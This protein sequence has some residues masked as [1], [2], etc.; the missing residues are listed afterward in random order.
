MIDSHCH[1]DFAAFDHDREQV[2]QRA[3]SLGVNQILVPGTQAKRWQ[4]QRAICQQF[5]NLKFA[6]GLHP[7]FLTEFNREDL[8]TLE[9]SLKHCREHVTAVGEIGLDFAIDIDRALQEDVFIQQLSIAKQA[10]LPVILHHRKSHNDLIRILKSTQFHFGGVIHAFSGSYQ[11]G[12]AYVD[13]G[14]KLGVGGTIT[15]PRAVK[16]IDAIKRLPLESLLLETDAPDMPMSGR[17]GERN[18][19]EYLPDVLEALSR[20]RKENK[21]QLEAVTDLNFAA[22]F[23]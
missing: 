15:Y 18:S 6:L 11:Q 13:M 5:D 2:I 10:R 1:L 9:V 3:A 12:K 7:Y 22:L 8:D 17:Q 16:T 4:K 21:R 23:G 14:F 20:I 19:P